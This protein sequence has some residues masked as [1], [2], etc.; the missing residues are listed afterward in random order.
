MKRQIVNQIVRQIYIYQVRKE[1]KQKDKQKD[2][3]KM[4]RKMTWYVDRQLGKIARQIDELL[5]Y[6]KKNALL[7]AKIRNSQSVWKSDY[8]SIYI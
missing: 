8:L 1:K 6:N 7:K 2:R 5:T 4:D 3:Y